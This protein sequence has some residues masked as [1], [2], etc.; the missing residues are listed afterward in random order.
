MKAIDPNLKDLREDPWYAEYVSMSAE[1][2]RKPY[3]RPFPCG[4]L[5]LGFDRRKVEMIDHKLDISNGLV[6]IKLLLN[7][8]ETAY[9]KVFA[10][11]DKDRVWMKLLD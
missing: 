3:P 10:D 9:L 8:E 2:Y 4:S 11:M 6:T 1:N 7:N 5:I